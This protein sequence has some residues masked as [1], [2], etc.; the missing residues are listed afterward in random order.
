MT[1]QTLTHYDARE[2]ALAGR[3]ASDPSAC[4][5][6]VAQMA[7]EPTEQE[8]SDGLGAIIER[9]N[10]RARAR[11]AADADTTPYAYPKRALT[12]RKR[13]KGG[14]IVTVRAGSWSARYGVGP[15]VVKDLFD[16]SKFNDPLQIGVGPLDRG[17]AW[18]ILLSDIVNVRVDQA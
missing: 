6:C 14:S 15:F 18:G 8:L 3:D 2:C 16:R 4:K 13:G 10:A 11:R 17:V 12:A 1:N 9:A 7:T 5:A